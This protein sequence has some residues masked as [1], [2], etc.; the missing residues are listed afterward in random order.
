[1]TDNIKKQLNS[2]QNLKEEYMELQGELQQ[3]EA[4]IP[5]ANL[6]GM[7][8]APGV[9]NPVERAALKHMA[10]MDKCQAKL[11]DIATSLTWIEDMIEGLETV[12]RRIARLHYIDGLKWEDVCVKIN[13]SWRQTHRIHGRLLDKLATAEI[14]RRQGKNE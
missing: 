5:G 13:Y 10:L 12:E 1:M 4:Y 14:E 6:D 2:Y 3:L 9:G 8:K 11:D 7:P